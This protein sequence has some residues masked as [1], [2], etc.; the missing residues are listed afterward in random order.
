M[1]IDNT[2]YFANYL[3]LF[4]LCPQ[5]TSLNARATLSGGCLQWGSENTFPFNPKSTKNSGGMTFMERHS[6]WARL[7]TS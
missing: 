4:G 6:I 1:A 7:S 5:R 3:I 2:K